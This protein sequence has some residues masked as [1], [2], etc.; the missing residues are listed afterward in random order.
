MVVVIG[1]AIAF[2]SAGCTRFCTGHDDRA[3]PL[4]GELGLP[5]DDAPGGDAGVTAIEAEPDAAHKHCDV[6]LAEAGVCARRA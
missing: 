4:S 5:G 6:V 2:S 1:V 3:R